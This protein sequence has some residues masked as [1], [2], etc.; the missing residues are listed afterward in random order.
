MNADKKAAIERA[1]RAAERT[2]RAAKTAGFVRTGKAAYAE[3]AQD[4]YIG[5]NLKR[6][7]WHRHLAPILEAYRIDL[8]QIEDREMKI[9]IDGMNP[10]FDPE[11]AAMRHDLAHLEDVIGRHGFVRKT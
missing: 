3:P 6:E 10:A 9:Q 2:E 11:L 5:Q 7:A 4:E 8:V 1:D